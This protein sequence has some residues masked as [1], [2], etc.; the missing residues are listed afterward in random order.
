MTGKTAIGSLEDRVYINCRSLLGIKPI[1]I[2]NIPTRI[3][4][5]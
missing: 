1:D 3:L 4:I 2:Q 5:I